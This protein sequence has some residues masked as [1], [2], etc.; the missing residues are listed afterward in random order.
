MWCVSVADSFIG[1]QNCEA[2]TSD[3]IGL[4]FVTTM[5]GDLGSN[6]GSCSSRQHAE[7]NSPIHNYQH[8]C[9]APQSTKPPEYSQQPVEG[10]DMSPPLAAQVIIIF[11]VDFKLVWISAPA[12]NSPGNIKYKLINFCYALAYSTAFYSADFF[13]CII[14][15][16]LP[17]HF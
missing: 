15:Q 7:S 11:M 10:I 9:Q 3:C 13:R 2:L 8:L 4:Q 5:S 12:E 16:V 14:L 17:L 6:P 1:L